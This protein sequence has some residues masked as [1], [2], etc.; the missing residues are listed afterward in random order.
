[1]QRTQDFERLVRFGD[2][3]ANQRSLVGPG[4]TVSVARAGVP[5]ARDDALVVRDR[6]VNDVNQM[7][8]R[9][10]GRLMEAVSEAKAWPR[11]G[12]P[13]RIILDAVITSSHVV[14]QSFDPD[15]H[16][17]YEHLGP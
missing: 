11:P 17:V 6:A 10:P 14:G 1:M 9:P 4:L 15:I 2:R 16:R 13:F 7:A 12:I 3:C 5:G 8:A